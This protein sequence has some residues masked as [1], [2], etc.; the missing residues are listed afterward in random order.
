MIRD[1]YSTREINQK[2]P[3]NAEC[4]IKTGEIAKTLNEAMPINSNW[5]AWEESCTEYKIQQLCVIFFVLSPFL[6]LLIGE[7]GIDGKGI[8]GCRGEKGDEGKRIIK[9]GNVTELWIK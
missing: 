4:L 6:S 3:I 5:K 1:L 2:L 9:G 8:K 7:P